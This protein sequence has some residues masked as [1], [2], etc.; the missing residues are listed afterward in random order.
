MSPLGLDDLVRNRTLSPEMAATLVVAVRER[1]GLLVAAIP[2]LAGKTTTMT[3]ALAEAEV[4]VHVLSRALPSLGVPAERDSGYLML[5]EIA[6]AP[7]AEYLWGA[8]VRAAFAAAREGGFAI[9]A[10]LHAG[11]VEEAFDIIRGNAVP[12]EDAERLEVMVY[13]RT[14]GRDW[15]APQRRVV[16]AMY[17]IL[18]VTSGKPE[19][20]LLYHWDEATDRFEVDGG[21]S[22]GHPAGADFGVALQRFEAVL[23]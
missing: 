4:P 21:D 9:A 5:S 19:A 12:D 6:P 22:S 17:E 16:A 13:I 10:A 15:T 20:R 1:R 11:G 2:R 18:W 7:F 14:L 8:P 23:A 3:A